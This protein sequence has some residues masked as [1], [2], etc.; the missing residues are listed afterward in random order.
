MAEALSDERLAEIRAEIEDDS[1]GHSYDGGQ[2]ARELL[3]EVDRMRQHN[4]MH[5]YA[6]PITFTEDE[7]GR[8]QP[9]WPTP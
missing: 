5:G 9:Q 1:Y 2:A 3:A 6:A 7:N 8:P 4:A